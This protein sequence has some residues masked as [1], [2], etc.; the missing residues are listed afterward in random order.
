M[1]AHGT[2]RYG[3]NTEGRL[4]ESNAMLARHLLQVISEPFLDMSGNCKIRLQCES[5]LI[6]RRLL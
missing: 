2:T 6:L 1:L 4:S 5:I 3:V